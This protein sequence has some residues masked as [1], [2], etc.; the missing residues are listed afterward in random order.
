M[1][2]QTKTC[3]VDVLLAIV[4]ELEAKGIGFTVDDYIRISSD[5]IPEFLNDP[6]SFIARAHGVSK[7]DYVSFKNNVPLRCCG[8]TRRGRRCKNELAG[9]VDIQTYS[10][11]RGGFCA[12]HGR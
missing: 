4:L 8:I 2:V 1:S 9:Q 5:D 10:R 7:G 3:Q 11:L 6:E 12:I